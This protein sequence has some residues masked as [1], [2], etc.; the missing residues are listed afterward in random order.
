VTPR[1]SR[2][3]GDTGEIPNRYRGAGL[4]LLPLQNSSWRPRRWRPKRDLEEE[5]ARACFQSK[6]S[7]GGGPGPFFYIT[8]VR[9]EALGFQA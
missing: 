5:R 4:G 7:N 1:V 6:E 9:G 2:K 3:F 8:I